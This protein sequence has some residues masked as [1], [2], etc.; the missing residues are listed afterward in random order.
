MNTIVDKPIVLK[1]NKNWQQVGFGLVSKALVDLAAGQTCLALDI[2]YK[3]NEDGTPNLD[4]I[5]F[6]RPVV[7]DE[8]ITLPVR[9]WE[10]GI[11]TSKSRI[12]CPTI[13]IAKNY[14]KMPERKWKGKPSKKAIWDRDGGV[15]QYT[16]LPLE[17]DDATLD[18]V[19]PKFHGG[20]DDWDNLAL[21][22][23][24]INQKKGHK[25]NEEIGLK[26]ISKP[27][28]PKPVPV[29]KLIQRPRHP[30]HSHFIIPVKK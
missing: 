26:L 30:D 27:Y 3:I 18:H 22:H 2:N 19:I 20:S 6:V 29:W 12:R 17:Y 9:S 7:W 11:N 13:T 15:D 1:L 10:F 23:R 4:E 24:Q 8:W 14:G 5:E 25:K 28:K 21:T 16:G